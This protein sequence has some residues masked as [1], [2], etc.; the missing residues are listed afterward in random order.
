[1]NIYKLLLVCVFIAFNLTINAQYNLNQKVSDALLNYN[2]KSYPEKVYVHSDKTYYFNEENIWFTLYMVNGITHKKSNKSLLAYVELLNAKDSIIDR[3]KLFMNSLSTPG[4]FKLSKKIKPGTYKLKAYTN[5]MKNQNSAYFFD[6][7]ITI[8]SFEKKDTTH[9]TINIDTVANVTKILKPDL[10]FYPQGGYLVNGLVNK[11]AIKLKN[12]IY[13]TVNLRGVIKDQNGERIT[14]FVSTK[15]GL[16]EFSIIPEK[17][18]KY[19]ATIINNKNTFS[20]ELPKALE[21]GFVLN[22]ANSNEKLYISLDANTIDG[23]MGSSLVIH[24]RGKLIYNQKIKETSSKKILKI[25]VNQLNNGVIHATLFNKNS[26]AVCERLVF[27]YKNNAPEISI[28]KEKDYYSERKQVKLKI[29]VTNKENTVIP[30]KLSLSIKEVKTDPKEDISDNIKTW[31][32]LNSDLRGKIKNPNFFFKNKDVRKSM[33]LLDLIMLTH[34]WRKFTWQDFLNN[35]LDSF[36]YKPEKGFMIEGRVKAIKN[37]KKLLHKFTRVTFPAGGFFK[38]EPIKKTDSIGNYSY[39]PFVFFDS[40]PV[41]IEARLNS[42]TSKNKQDRKVIINPK[43]KQEN[44]I[45]SNKPFLEKKYTKSFIK[46]IT[47]QQKKLQKFSNEFLK[48]ENVLEEIVVK[49][50]LKTSKS[51]RYKEMNARAS[52]GNAFNRNDLSETSNNFGDIFNLLSTIGT[53]TVLGNK[54]IVNRDN[55]ESVVPLILYDELPIEIDELSGIPASEI[56][57]VDVLTGPEVSLF[58]TN[59]PVISIFSKKNSGGFIKRAPGITNYKATGFYTAKEFY[60]PDHINGI[61]EKTKPDPRT[62]LH[63]VPN[64]IIT[65]DKNVEISFFTSD[66]KGKYVIEIEGITITGEPLYKTSKIFVE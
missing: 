14:S 58:S 1:M 5:Y 10:N 21:K 64:I 32:L 56:S 52:Y 3:K 34:G 60:A 59:S 22:I 24:Q 12:E 23:L 6:K 40:I 41:I 39:G 51:E 4:N 29:N 11:V 25:P 49:S 20:Y 45:I 62:T 27:I 18:K 37:S 38:Q 42:F 9:K 54:I 16:G 66:V 35:E 47:E 19:F 50:K 31:L 55:D 44:K 2:L 57:F 48:S 13:N 46:S 53:I 36:P 61:E 8:W 33:Y 7:E 65:K 15:F 43:L 26:Q 63:W 28:K 30:S 17:G